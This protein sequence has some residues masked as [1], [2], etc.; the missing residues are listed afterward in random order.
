MAF[1]LAQV[2]A[3]SHRVA[4]NVKQNVMEARFCG[5]Q[6][7]SGEK[8]VCFF[9]IFAFSLLTLID[10]WGDYLGEWEDLRCAGGGTR[11][12]QGWTPGWGWA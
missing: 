5:E 7:A 11:S 4:A 12:L 8:A 3:E 2:R 10:G 6:T 1:R 9:F